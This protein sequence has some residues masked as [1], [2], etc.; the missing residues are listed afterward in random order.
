MR[1]L[2]RSGHITKT[3]CWMANAAVGQEKQRDNIIQKANPPHCLP[4]RKVVFLPCDRFS[5][6]NWNNHSPVHSPSIYE[7]VERVYGK[8]KVFLGGEGDSTST[9][10]YYLNGVLVRPGYS[11]VT[12]VGGYHEPFLT[13]VN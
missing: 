8:A 13:A 3:L 11:H 1:P 6:H 4:S 12:L 7:I 10:N 9:N 5:G 2:Q